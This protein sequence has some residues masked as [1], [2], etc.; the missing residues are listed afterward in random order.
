MSEVVDLTLTLREGM[1]TFPVYWHPL[2]E[3]SQLGRLHYEKRETRKLVLGT[4][5]G[6]HMDAPRHFIVGGKTIDELDPELFVGECVLLN[7]TDFGPFTEVSK[8]EMEKRLAGRTPRRLMLRFDWS[9]HIN[10]EAYYSDHPYLSEECAQFLVDAG[11]KVLAMD[12]PMPD[13]PKNGRNSDNDS[14]NHYIL[15]GKDVILV[16][17]VTNLRAL[18]DVD[19][20]ELFVLPLKIHEGDGAPVRCLG[21][22]A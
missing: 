17:Y 3:I 2:V 16:E 1:T 14:P 9:D 21:R 5:T 7:M 22:I 15:L 19:T 10:S 11:V 8:A 12:T 20:F 4:H 6:T 18:G 13:N